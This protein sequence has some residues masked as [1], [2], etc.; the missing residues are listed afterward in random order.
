[1][2]FLMYAEIHKGSTADT[3]MFEHDPKAIYR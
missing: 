3:A 1:M 2:N